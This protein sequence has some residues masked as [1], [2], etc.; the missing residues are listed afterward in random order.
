[1]A[2]GLSGGRAVQPAGSGIPSLPAWTQPAEARIMKPR[3]PHRSSEENPPGRDVPLDD[4]LPA[5]PPWRGERACCCPAQPVVR[6]I[7]AP[8]AQRWHSVDLLLCGHHYRVSRRAL[9]AA[10][11]RIEYLPGK[12]EAAAAALLED[13]CRD[14][15]RSGPPNP[16]IAR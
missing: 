7:M 12:A 2:R 8:A 4:C 15:D 3:F 9:A 16:R 11:A 5:L 13:P 10:G 1:M 14:H 6:T